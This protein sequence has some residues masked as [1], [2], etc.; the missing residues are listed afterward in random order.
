MS[1]NSI[2]GC[3]NKIITMN[4]KKKSNLL[5]CKDSKYSTGTFPTRSMSINSI[6]VTMSQ[7]DVHNEN[8]KSSYDLH[9]QMSDES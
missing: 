7:Q 8:L 4:K 3:L 2:S 1:V 5:D 9:F 6:Y